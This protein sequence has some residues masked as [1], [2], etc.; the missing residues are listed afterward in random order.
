MVGLSMYGVDA[1]IILLM[2]PILFAKIFQKESIVENLSFGDLK[3]I[4]SSGGERILFAI[5]NN[6]RESEEI[7]AI[8]LL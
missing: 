4:F 5:L 8:F 2:L 3:R 1:Q 6:L 7:N